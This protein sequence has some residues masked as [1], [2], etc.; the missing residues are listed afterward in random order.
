M[1]ICSN[2]FSLW[3]TLQCLNNFF[4]SLRTKMC[5]CVVPMGSGSITPTVN[6][7]MLVNSLNF[8]FNFVSMCSDSSEFFILQVVFCLLCH[9]TTCYTFI[10][11]RPYT[12]CCCCSVKIIN[13]QVLLHILTTKKVLRETCSDT[14]S[15]NLASS[16][17]WRASCCDFYE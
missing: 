12:C 11:C 6:I 15:E 2:S 9:L 7:L 1:T 5:Q 13:L 3:Q 17:S 8:T 4:T 10:F 14:C 16:C